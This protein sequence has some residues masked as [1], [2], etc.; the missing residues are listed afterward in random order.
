M[1]EFVP[2][3]VI[4]GLPSLSFFHRDQATKSLSLN[5]IGFR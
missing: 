2:S 1:L 5:K 3:R 4:H